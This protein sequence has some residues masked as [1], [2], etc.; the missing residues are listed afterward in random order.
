[1]AKKRA[2]FLLRLFIWFLILIAAGAV[3]VFW[4]FNVLKS[5][6]DPLGQEQAFV[7]QKGESID[8]ISKSL[9]DKGL[10]RSDFMFKLL[11]KL[12]GSTAH[13]EAGDFKISPAMSTE[14]VIAALGK[15]AED[16]WVTL[17]EGWRVEQMASDLHDELGIDPGDF[18]KAAKGHE[19][20]LFPDTY[21]FNKNVA[22]ET[23]VQTLTSTFDKKYSDNLQAKV[24]KN[25]LTPEEGI[26][27]ASIVEREGR[28]DQVRKNVASILLKRFNMEMALNAD[29][30][31]QYA[32]DSQILNRGG[33]PDKFWQPVTLADYHD[34]VSTYNTYLHSGLP[35]APICNPSLSSLQAVADADPSIPYLY[36]YVDGQGKIYYAKTLAE[37]ETNVSRHP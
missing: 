21:L 29:A 1:M 35:P 17:L 2:P 19:G 31:V 24:R 7:V 8:E 14:E 3:V 9:V 26:I 18:I 30:T 4:Q 12:Q 10:I 37:H 27:L 11:V 16:K 23:I 33:T 25:G 13:I 15:G 22:A 28:S 5:P 20:H 6:I 32:K 34:I 36:Y